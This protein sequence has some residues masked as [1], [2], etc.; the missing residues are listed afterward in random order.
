MQQQI[1]TLTAAVHSLRKSELSSVTGARP[2]SAS[3]L[4]GTTTHRSV[5]RLSTAKQLAF[6]GPTTSAFSFDLA[7]SSLQSR[8]IVER[9]ETGEEGEEEEE[10]E[11]E[12]EEEEEEEEESEQMARKLP[13]VASP[14]PPAADAEFDSRRHSDPLWAINKTEAL[15]LCQ[16]YEDEMGI[17]YPVLDLRQLLYHVELLYKTLDLPSWPGH[18]AR[19]MGETEGI[20]NADIYI[21]RLVFACA[22]TAEGSGRSEL[23]I[24]LF[25]SVRDVADNCVWGAPDMKSII[26]LMLVVSQSRAGHARLYIYTLLTSYSVNLL[27]SDGRGDARLANNRNRRAH[28]S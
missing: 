25:D 8:G 9:Q 2:R 17:M 19:S 24:R 7:K 4:L 14:S 3:Q 21:L 1:S 26:F 27:L 11:D 16:V 18:P 6:Q 28:V 10:E 5:R 23:A 20:E 13:P 22:L 15:R 12:E